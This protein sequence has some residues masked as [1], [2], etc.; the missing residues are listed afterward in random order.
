M[1]LNRAKALYGSLAFGAGKAIDMYGVTAI[2]SPNAEVMRIVLRIGIEKMIT[3]ASAKDIGKSAK[4]KGAKLSAER[5]IAM[6][7]TNIAIMITIGGTIATIMM[8]V[9]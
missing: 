4:K 3:G 6:S 1:P 2:G 5:N 9:E 8:I 7:V